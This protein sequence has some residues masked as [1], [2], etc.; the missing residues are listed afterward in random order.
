[1][2]QITKL[3]SN[4]GYIISIGLALILVSSLV[5]GYYLVTHLSPPEGYTTIYL[6]DSS[7]KKAIDYPE[8]LII[9]FNSTFKVWVDVEN[10]MGKTI[11]GQVRLKI[12]DEPISNF[13]VNVSSIDNFSISNLKNDQTW[14]KEATITIN[15]SGNY[16]VIFEL[17][18]SSEFSHNYCVLN[19]EVADTL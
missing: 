4:K 12:T 10:H 3:G 15:K 1:L 9:N 18:I 17:W 19:V 14:E 5:L 7:Q 8:L 13:P 11:Q 2:N 16:S 6:L